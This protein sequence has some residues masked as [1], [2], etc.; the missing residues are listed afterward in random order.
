MHAL[1]F[2]HQPHQVAIALVFRKL[3]QIPVIPFGRGHRLVSVI[4]RGFAKRMIVPFDTGDLTGF[5]T[6]ARRYIDVFADFLG[7]LR[8]LTGHGSG[9][10]RDFLNLK[11]LWVAHDRS[12][13]ALQ[14]WSAP[15]T[16]SG[17]GALVRI[18]NHVAFIYPKR[19]RAALAAAL[20]NYTFSIFTKKPLNSG[21]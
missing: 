18:R 14:I 2:A 8:A 7:A 6:N 17:D 11:C 20:Q 3:N 15:A 4:E 16:P 13:S 12:F 19:R 9:M 5:A 10:G 1:I 21:V